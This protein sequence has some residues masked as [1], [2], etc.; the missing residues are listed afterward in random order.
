MLVNNENLTT[1]WF[2]DNK[3]SVQII[4]QRFLPHQLQIVTLSSLEDAEYAIKS[5]QQDRKYTKHPTNDTGGRDWITELK[6]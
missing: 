1:I 5:A 3:S 6:R 4:D 2:D